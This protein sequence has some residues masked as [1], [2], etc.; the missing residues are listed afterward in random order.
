LGVKSSKPDM[1]AGR[2]WKLPKVLKSSEGAHLSEMS[3][4]GQS[5]HL[6]GVANPE[7]HDE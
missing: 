6:R 3:T 5:E 7:S 2:L 1:A 4:F